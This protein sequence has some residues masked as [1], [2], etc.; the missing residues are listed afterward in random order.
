MGKRTSL[1]RVPQD[2]YRTPG[3]A[4]VPLL[5]FLPARSRFVE[6]CAGDGA[7]VETLE[8]AGHICVGAFDINPRGPHIATGDAAELELCD[9]ALAITNPPWKWPWLAPIVMNLS[10]Q[11]PTWLLLNADLMH[12]VR[13]APLMARCSDVVSVGRVKWIADSPHSGLENAAW[14]RFQHRPCATLF[15]HRQAGALPAI[16]AERN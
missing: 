3:A 13:S 9:A 2:F 11:L 6:P 4:V 16:L 1:A 7:L 10:R 12:N 15:H 8:A 14:F 5:P